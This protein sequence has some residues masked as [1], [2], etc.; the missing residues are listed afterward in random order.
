MESHVPRYQDDKQKRSDKNFKCK[1][2][3]DHVKNDSTENMGFHL[4]LKS[5]PFFTITSTERKY[6]FP[7]EKIIFYYQLHFDF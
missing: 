5:L 6:C 2:R 3:P 4:N 7:Y 1:K